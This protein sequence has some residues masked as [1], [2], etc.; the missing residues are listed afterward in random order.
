MVTRILG[1]VIGSC[2]GR[3]C[4]TVI[5]T[6]R[7]TDNRNSRATCAQCDR[8]DGDGLH[9]PFPHGLSISCLHDLLPELILDPHASAAGRF[10]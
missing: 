5:S 10:Q 4:P 2:Y 6:H 7:V 1:G 8:Q 3:R 9:V